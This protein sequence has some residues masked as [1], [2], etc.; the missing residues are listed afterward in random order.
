MTPMSITQ[1][2]TTRDPSIRLEREEARVAAAHSAAAMSPPRIAV[3]R[4]SVRAA[5]RVCGAASTRQV[6]RPTCATIRLRARHSPRAACRR[7]SN[8]SEVSPPWPRRPAPGRA[9]A[10]RQDSS[11]SVR[12]RAATRS[13]SRAAAPR[14]HTSRRPWPS[15]RLPAIRRS[16]ANAA[17][18]DALSALDRAAKAGAIH[19][20]AAARRKS[21][22]TRKVNAALGGTAVQA[23]GHVTK[24]TGK[25]PP[26][27][28]PRPASRPARPARPR[29]PRRPP[30][31]PVPR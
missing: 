25:P 30:A 21:R 8:N 2:S 24:S 29:A 18:I 3:T 6:A 10:R 22:L 12:P 7:Q 14:R 17:L 19:P 4:T 1:P 9:L 23:G 5:W 20:N 11:A 16:I 15:P 31:R 13:S 27:R 26:R 28:P